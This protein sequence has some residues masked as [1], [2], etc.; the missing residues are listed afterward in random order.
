MQTPLLQLLIGISFFILGLNT[1][2]LDLKYHILKRT[3]FWSYV[4]LLTIFL[5]G[6]Y[7]IVPNGLKSLP[8][9]M[10]G[11]I[12]LLGLRLFRPN[13]SIKKA[14]Y[15]S[16]VNSSFLI[17]FLLS[18]L[19]G[20]EDYSSLLLLLLL[21]QF[22]GVHV[23]IWSINR[24]FYN[25]LTVT[26]LILLLYL[27]FDALIVQNFTKLSP[28]G[29]FILGYFVSNTSFSFPYKKKIKNLVN[30][31][32]TVLV[33]FI[34][35]LLLVFAIEDVDLNEFNFAILTG[36]ILVT[37]VVNL[38]CLRNYVPFI[39]NLVIL[40]G[41]IYSDVSE[42]III[43]F[44]LANI[45]SVLISLK[46]FGKRRVYLQ[47]RNQ[48]KSVKSLEQ[49]INNGIIPDFK[50]AGNTNINTRESQVKYNA[51]DYGIVPN[52]KNDQTDEINRFI[53]Q[54]G[55]QGG[56]IL[57]FPKGKY[58]I[59]AKR[60]SVRNIQINFSNIYLK[61]EVENDIV[62]TEFISKNHTLIGDKNPWLSP[63][64]FHFG[65]KL[66]D[67]NKFWGVQFAKWK[68]TITKSD[69]ITDPGS[70][71]EIQEAEYLTKITS[72]SKKGECV[73]KAEDEEVLKGKKF[74]LVAL[75]NTSGED[76][77]I[78][79]L[80]NVKKL[81][82][83][84]KN[85]L[86][87]GS[88]EAPSLQ[89]L[90][91]ID[92]VDGD[93]I[94][95]KVP[96]KF[97]IELKYAPKIYDAPLIEKVGISDLHIRSEWDGL[98][99]HHGAPFY[100]SKEQSQA[101]DY[102]WNGINICRVSKGY[103]SNLI[104]DNFTNPIYV[105]DS[106]NCTVQD[107]L[108]KGN[109]GHQGIKL[110]GHSCDNLFKE[111]RFENHY[112]DMIGGE[113]N[114][115]GNVFSSIIYENEENKPVDFDFHGCSE[116]PFSPPSFNLFENCKGF[117][118]IKGAGAPYNQPALGIKNVWWNIEADGFEGS[119]EIFFHASYQEKMWIYIT[120]SAVFAVLKDVLKKKS[121]FYNHLK[122]VYIAKIERSREFS[123]PIKSHYNQFKNSIICGYYNDYDMTIG[124]EKILP[125][126]GEIKV[127][128]LNEGFV[129]PYS[130]YDWQN[131]QR[132]S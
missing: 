111:I 14:S 72:S 58:Y 118:G 57:F 42:D 8:L 70:T 74:V 126:E 68:K 115:Y 36:S 85:P 103:F 100:Y 86:R 81:H 73:L 97:D 22:V 10:V 54:I 82:S 65:L 75:F 16:L 89:L 76:D 129:E 48:A 105:Q 20:L 114:C 119:S 56:G 1:Y 24:F 17:I 11:G 7:A 30:S 12:A 69:S 91:E 102:G 46:V 104:L 112:A 61:G 88:E 116:G 26:V 113:G 64:L 41:L 84:W 9:I 67:S 125:K 53:E 95:L 47:K 18:S 122:K 93:G 90:I 98:F 106:L 130:L 78:K 21:V 101:M 123:N 120:F 13:I 108:V 110:Y 35:E 52:S 92:R 33:A 27:S 40:Q 49:H 127:Y 31:R 63:F 87:A 19:V 3:R 107:S 28:W 60:G 23:I 132:G 50:Y 80:L 124:G 34:L 5:T 44:G 62:V 15:S 59:N 71:G 131:E 25:K 117:R 77:L 38:F 51:V 79:K 109:D 96:L 128:S 39:L 37:V 55:K 29:G 2:R 45:L 99:R 6:L 32:A 83:H 94:K 121:L 4:A 43:G 66:Q